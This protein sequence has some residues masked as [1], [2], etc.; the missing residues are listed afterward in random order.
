VAWNVDGLCCS[1]GAAAQAVPRGTA[2]DREEPGS[3]RLT[4]AA[5]PCAAA[6]SLGALPPGLPCSRP[7]SR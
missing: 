3:S 1:P 6:Q 7:R 2:G 4:G 5:L